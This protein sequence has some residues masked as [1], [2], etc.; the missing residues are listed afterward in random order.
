M[1][2][3]IAVA[4]D[5]I[6]IF[7]LWGRIYGQETR[8][9]Y[10]YVQTYN[11]DIDLL[12]GWCPFFEA[13]KLPVI[14]GLSAADLSYFNV[15]ADVWTPIVDGFDSVG[16]RDYGLSAYG[17]VG[18]AGSALPP[19]NALVMRRRVGPAGRSNR[20]RV[21]LPGVPS[22][23]QVGGVLSGSGVVDAVNNFK[24]EMAREMYNEAEPTPLPIGSPILVKKLATG[25]PDSFQVV[26]Y[27]D[28][29]SCVRSQRRREPGVG[30]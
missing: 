27:W 26:N 10:G 13:Q 11:E 19:N 9:E 12:S 2:S 14:C 28:A 15:R 8:T 4:Q 22:G 21:Y 29:N 24:V 6:I 7:S 17:S 20:G 16:W 25:F 1:P 3:D 30:I 23:W 18:V 5:D